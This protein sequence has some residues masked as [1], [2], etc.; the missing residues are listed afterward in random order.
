MYFARDI[1]AMVASV[2]SILSPGADA[3]ARLAQRIAIGT[4]PVVIVGLLFNDV[5]EHSL[6]TP[7]GRRLR[8]RASARC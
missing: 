6:R 5:I 3:P 7:L 1:G 4:V 8:A 2:P